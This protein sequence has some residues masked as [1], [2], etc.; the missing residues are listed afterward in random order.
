MPSARDG[1]AADP[2]DGL[3]GLGLRAGDALDGLVG[4][5]LGGGSPPSMAASA[6]AWMAITPS[7]AASALAWI[8]TTP[9][10]AASARA[11]VAS[12]GRWRPRRGR[13]PRPRG[14]AARRPGRGSPPSARRAGRAGGRARGRRLTPSRTSVT[15]WNRSEGP[16]TDG[17]LMTGH[18]THVFGGPL[19][20]CAG[21]SPGRGGRSAARPAWC[22]PGPRIVG[23]GAQRRARAR[24]TTR[25]CRHRWGISRRGTA[26]VTVTSP[27]APAS[28]RTGSGAPEAVTVEQ[29]LARQGS[30]V[31]RRRAARRVE[32]ARRSPSRSRR[33]RSTR[34]PGSGPDCR[35][36]R[37]AVRQAGSSGPRRAGQPGRPGRRRCP[38]V[39][40]RRAGV[41]GSPTVPAVPAQRPDPAA[42]RAGSPPRRPGRPAKRSP[43]PAR[44]ERT[45]ASPAPPPAGARRP[46]AGGGRRR[47]RALPPRRS[48]STST[49]RSTG[50]RRWPPTGRRCWRRGLQAGAENYLVVG[51]GIPGQD[52]AASVATLLASVSADGDRAVLVSFPP[53]GAGRHPRRAAP[54]TARCAARSPRPSRPRCSR[55]G[56]RAW[57]APSSSSPGCGSTTT[58]TS[59]WPGCP[60]WSTRSAASRSASIPSAATD[61]RG[62]AAARR[63]PRPV[64]ATRPPAT[65]SPATPAPTSPA[66][67]WPSGPSG[68]SPRRC[69][70][71]CRRARSPIR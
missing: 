26:R 27:D 30:A 15:A 54:R 19:S 38:P 63:A 14:S 44:P 34:R 70:P 4:L 12:T 68:C 52:G 51:S 33:P 9:S 18:A 64:R 60:A 28:R 7:M 22:P 32:E 3:V 67:R 42:A 49:R 25:R 31:G 20:G 8:A 50:S 1:R 13:R 5:G 43:A 36:S 61:G 6:R 21:P 56:R 2:L 24:P 66:P 47:R 23:R 53:T 58:S 59:T 11:W 39:P 17:S 10:M 37:A 65:C 48:T 46:G 40:I 62:P 71:R 45:A 57:C 69:A 29:L 35:R 55:A 41:A 16:G